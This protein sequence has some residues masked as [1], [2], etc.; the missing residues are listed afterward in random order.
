MIPASA[1]PHRH[2]FPGKPHSWKAAMFHAIGSCLVVALL[3]PAAGT[4][5]TIA[6]VRPSHP[7]DAL[8]ATEIT[9]AAQ[10]LRSSGRMGAESR[11]GLLDLAEPDKAS[12]LRGARNGSFSRSA[13]AI[14]YDWA[15]D[16]VS[17]AVV[18][19]TTGRVTSFEARPGDQPPMR[20]L[21]ISRINETVKS[22]SSWLAAIRS[23]GIEDPA[24]VN[25]LASLSEDTP[26]ARVDGDLVV[27]SS[28]FMKNER[29]GSMGLPVKARVNLTRGTVLDVER[30]AGEW[31]P[32]E[33]ASADR[34]REALAPLDI[35][36]PDGPSFRIEGSAIRWQNWTIHYGVHARRG[37]EL[38][39]ISYRDAG[40]DRPVL[41][42][43][44]V[45]ET[46]TPYGDPEWSIWYPID[47]GDYGFGTY[48]IRS[49]VP[50]ADAPPN[51][52]FLAATL[53]DPMGRPYEVA[54]AVSI[55]ERDGGMLWRHADESRRKRDLV[56]GFVSAID[57]YDYIFN[58][59]FREDGTIDVEVQLSGVINSGST[60]LAA[61]TMPFMDNTVRHREIVAPNVTGP[62]H[63][64][65]FSYRL[66]FDIDGPAHNAVMEVET[67]RDA[68]GPANPDG[69]WFGTRERVLATELG[70]IRDLNAATGRAWRVI[71]RSSQNAL[72]RPAGF[73]LMPAGNAFPAP[74]AD[75][76]SRQKVGF[77]NAHLWVTPFAPA[78][79]HA[80][81]DYL[82]PG[83]RGGGLPAWTRADRSLDDADVVLW[84]TL[85]ITHRVRPEDYPLMPVH[86]AGF[87]LVPFGFF[88]ENPAMDVAGPTGR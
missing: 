88:A 36:Q 43:A 14:L 70:A 6:E 57:N 5:Q 86:T 31:T 50:G 75:A 26:V 46:L 79:M 33:R 71:N 66:D 45:T 84:Y 18:D 1:T 54:R 34:V 41:Y 82:P 40:R 37:L 4:A 24:E 12:V 42:R 49:A 77:V 28:A 63:Q 85:G 2:G 64:H 9:R 81:G 16:R 30:G 23:F 73:A 15:T 55:Y 76:P 27:A 19:L 72:G 35:R 17:E 3:L 29:P 83:V 11:F 61:D 74:A 56:I 21:I 52:V 68:R 32:S 44:A 65:F 62:V 80:A 22:D 38:F 10:I 48:G 60:R 7:L 39:D 51:A 53:P 13:R 87:S 8:T 69:N 25:M 67:E 47:E 58:W 78:E 20:H 59:I